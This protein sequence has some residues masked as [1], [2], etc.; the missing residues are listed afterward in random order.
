MTGRGTGAISTIQV[1]G[2]SLESV[3]EK[4]FKQAVDKPL[5]FET[6]QILLGSICDGNKTIDQVTIGCLAVSLGA[7]PGDTLIFGDLGGKGGLMID[8]A[9]DYFFQP[10]EGPTADKK[11]IFRVQLEKGLFRV[12]PST[13]GRN[14]GYRSLQDFE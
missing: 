12:F 3:I 14:V 5:K 8:S 9:G 7:P 10:V 1:F 2:E 6:G 4:I 13:F 11:D